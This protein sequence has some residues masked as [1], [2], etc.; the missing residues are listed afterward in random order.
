MSYFQD[1]V[2]QQV[3]LW[4]PSDVILVDQRPSFLHGLEIDIFLPEL[5]IGIEV[6]GHQC[7]AG[8][9]HPRQRGRKCAGLSHW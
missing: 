1:I 8:K 2:L 7:G 3:R 4:F 5:H 6:Q 9:A